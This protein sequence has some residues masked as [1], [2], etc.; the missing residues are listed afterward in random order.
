MR[1]DGTIFPVSY[2][3]SPLYENDNMTGSIIVFRDISKQKEDQERI[4]YMAFHDDLTKLPNLRYIKEKLKQDMLKHKS[5][6]LLIID[7]DRFKHIN[8][9]L[10]HSFGDL[11]LQIGCE[12]AERIRSH[13]MCLSAV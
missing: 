6:A 12:S 9:A 3:T 13:P 10:G 7:I 8:E 2:V 11:I 4:E 1:K 5:F